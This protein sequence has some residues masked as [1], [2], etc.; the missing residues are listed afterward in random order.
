M[1][2][3]E[4]ISVATSSGAQAETPAQKPPGDGSGGPPG[5]TADLSE[6]VRKKNEESATSAALRGGR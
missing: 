5:S 6:K 2:P 3:T 1:A 4:L